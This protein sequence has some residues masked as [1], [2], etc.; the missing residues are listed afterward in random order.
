MMRLTMLS[1]LIALGVCVASGAA[2]DPAATEASAEPASAP[3]VDLVKLELGTWDAVVEFPPAS[4]DAKPTYARGVQVNTLVGGGRWI[5]NDIEVE[6]SYAGHGTWGWDPRRQRYVG[7]WVD[8][9][10]DYVRLDEGRYDQA[11]RTL[12]WESE[13][14]QPE[15]HPPAKF[16][17]VEEFR[18]DTRVLTM[19]AIG[20]K[21]GK[22]VPLGKI[23]FTRRVATPAAAASGSP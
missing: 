11:T 8:S 15:P 22:V 19:T 1:M 9:N 7:I 20:P 4:P 18:G 5:R 6:P 23:T 21:T 13:L 17:L 10:T 16:R 14:R 2:A 12:T 3:E